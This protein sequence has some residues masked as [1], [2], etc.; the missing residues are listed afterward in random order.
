MGHP[1]DHQFIQRDF[2]SNQL[3]FKL[4]VS[5]H[6]LSPTLDELARISSI[7]AHSNDDLG[8]AL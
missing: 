7:V 1:L 8:P 3:T 6:A 4:G 2:D 5:L